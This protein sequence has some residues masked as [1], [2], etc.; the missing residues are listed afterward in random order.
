MTKK[1]TKILATLSVASCTPAF[2]R[3]LHEAG[4]DAVRI[5]TAHSTPEEAAP[6]IEMVRSVS[7]RIAVLVDTKGP[8]VRTRGIAEP[9]RVAEGDEVRIVRDETRAGARAFATSYPRFVDEVPAGAVV[10]IEDGMI[11]LEVV[12]RDTDTLVCRALNPGA[13]AVRK[14]VNVPSVRLDLP[15]LSGK[16][17]DFIRLAVRLGVDYIAHSFVRDSR[18]VAAVQGILDRAGGACRIIAKIENTQ[19]IEHLDEIL[20]ACAGVMIARGD[21]GV[22]IPFERLPVIQK[23]IIQACVRKAKVA[24]TATQMLHSMI[25]SPRPTRAEVSDV[26]NAVFDGTDVLMLSGETANGKY[27]LEAVRT[28]TRIAREA[29]AQRPSGWNVETEAT[30][31]HMRSYLARTAA[32]AVRAVPVK[33]IVANTETGRVARLVSSYR[34]GV[35]V[36]ARSPNIRT[37]R[38]LALSYGVYSEVLPP[39]AT[40]DQMIRSSLQPMLADGSIAPGDVVVVIGGTPGQS[41]ETNFV[42]INTAAQLLGHDVGA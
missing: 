29:E 19:G 7:Q 21:L 31:N 13:I 22:E 38:E 41:G 33:A 12:A 15:S 16:D 10:L 35:P 42:M 8:E 2:V 6:F 11:G 30:S 18:D 34:T 27:P 32:H 14:N 5:N 36:Y 28:M 26:A 24:V 23:K 9:I 3:D 20:D 37:V 1:L 40:T 25:E 39:Q 4:M 17:E